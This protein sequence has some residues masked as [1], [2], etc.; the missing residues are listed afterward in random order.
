[1]AFPFVVVVV[2][3]VCS[4]LQCVYL[5]KLYH[6]ITFLFI[7]QRRYNPKYRVADN[8]Q[9]PL[10]DIEI[11][12]ILKAWNREF[13]SGNEMTSAGFVSG[14]SVDGGADDIFA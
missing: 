7:L 11:E 3:S 6:L 8:E 9:Y 4:N 13:G 14:I 1:M 2:I 10:A 12:R 5:H